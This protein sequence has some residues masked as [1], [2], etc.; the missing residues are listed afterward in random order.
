MNWSFI[1]RT[2]KYALQAGQ[3][4]IKIQELCQVENKNSS[5]S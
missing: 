4:L 3:S 1:K 2:I 5:I